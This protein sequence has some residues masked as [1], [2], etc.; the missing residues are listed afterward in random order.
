MY[1]FAVCYRILILADIRPM[2]YKLAC[3]GS[4]W[5]KSILGHCEIFKKKTYMFFIFIEMHRTYFKWIYTPGPLESQNVMV[6]TNGKSKCQA[7]GSVGG[8]S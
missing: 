6:W 3:C 5:F 8:Y 4:I 2:G 1:I 7:F